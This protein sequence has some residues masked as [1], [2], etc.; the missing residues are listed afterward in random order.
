MLKQVELS[1]LEQGMFVHKLDGNWL[2]HPF[3]KSQFMIEDAKT[4]ASIKSSKLRG[5]IIDTAKGRDVG[6]YPRPQ[7]REATGKA[8]PSKAE[9]SRMK[10]ALQRESV[11][12]VP[13]SL[14]KELTTAQAISD[15]AKSQLGQVLLA[16]RLGKALNVKTVEPVVA[17]IMLSVRRNSQAFSGLMRCKLQNELM[18]RHALSVSALMVS[19]ARRMKLPEDEVRNCGLA[20][21]LLDIG[22]SYLPKGIDPPHGDYRNVAPKIWKQHVMLGYRA[23]MNDNDLPQ[24]ILDAC[25]QHHERMDGSGYPGGLEGDEISTAARMAAVCDTFDFLLNKTNGA[26]A[27]DP[28]AAIQ[29]MKTMEDAFDPDILRS[30]IESVGLFP[31]GSFVVL[32]SEKLAM[33]IDEDFNDHTKPVVQAFYCLKNQ[34]RIRPFTIKL[35]DT[36]EDD[37]IVSVADL[38]EFNLPEDGQLREMIF[39]TAHKVQ[40]SLAEG[41]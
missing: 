28:A 30:F 22:V 20:G 9:L 41:K 36:N 23:L 3:W 18:F 25:L 17:D 27:L 5:A 29:R 7:G 32:S 40:E 12:T 10:K 38:S 13:V 8:G 31:V 6:A 16:A 37:A 14:R 1:A 24:S 34:E 15:R 2:D 4:L 26:P 39:L 33:V 19:L 35:A 11:A 21:L